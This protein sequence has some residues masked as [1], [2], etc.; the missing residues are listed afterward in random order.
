VSR[1]QLRNKILDIVSESYGASDT[2]DALA[3]LIDQY[4]YEYAE[5]VIGADELEI[6]GYGQDGKPNIAPDYVFLNSRNRLREQQ[7]KTNQELPPND[8]SAAKGLSQLPGAPT[9]GGKL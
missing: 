5:R 1:Q 7:R 4:A 3:N 8:R 6:T 9:R 2:A